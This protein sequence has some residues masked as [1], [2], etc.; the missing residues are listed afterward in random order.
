[1]E[2]D[3]VFA[4]DGVGRKVMRYTSGHNDKLG[5]SFDAI[6]R[7]WSNGEE[8]RVDKDPLSRSLTR[9]ENTFFG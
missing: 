4:V 7:V 5:S 1:M 8:L 6:Y 2:G 3:L 9:G